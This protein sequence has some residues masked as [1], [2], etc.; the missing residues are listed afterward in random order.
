MKNNKFIMPSRRA[1]VSGIL[2]VLMFFQMNINVMAFD[3]STHEYVTRTSLE[4]FS[5]LERKDNEFYEEKI[6][7]IIL[8]YCTKPDEDE[9]EGLYKDHFYNIATERNFMGEKISALVKFRQHYRN[10]LINYKKGRMEKCW[11]ELGRAIHFLEDINTPVH[12]GYDRPTDAVKRL[13]MHVAFEKTCILVQDE[14][15]ADINIKELQ[16]YLDNS[17]DNI[18]KMCARRSND[19][20]F[21]LKKGYISESEIAKRAIIDAQRNVVGIL[22]KFTVDTGTEHQL[23]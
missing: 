17:L 13:P 8:V 11:E 22:Y 2:F 19:N 4:L 6:K 15:L 10:A 14:C 5:K 9:N 12:G 1:I 3:G 18:G 21:A 16:Y 7:K 20:Y 23:Y